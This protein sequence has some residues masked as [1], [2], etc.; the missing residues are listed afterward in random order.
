MVQRQEGSQGRRSVSGSKTF[1]LTIVSTSAEHG[2]SYYC[3]IKN[4]VGSVKSSSAKVAVLPKPYANKPLK[5]LDLAE[6]KNA[7]LRQ[8]P[9]R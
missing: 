1:E 4:S 6:G 9:R 5:S 8:H 3:V 7:L 2:G